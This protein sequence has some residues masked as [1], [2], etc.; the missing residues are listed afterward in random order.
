M[1]VIDKARSLIEDGIE[2]DDILEI[3]NEMF[4]ECRMELQSV[5]EI[6]EEDDDSDLIVTLESVLL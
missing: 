6:L 4:P 5:S 3:L 2:N 1:T